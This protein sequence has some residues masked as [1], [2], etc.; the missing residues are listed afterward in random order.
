MAKKRLLRKAIQV[1][2][3]SVDYVDLNRWS[4]ENG[5]SIGAVIRDMVRRERERREWAGRDNMAQSENAGART[6]GRAA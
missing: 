1:R 4:V 5:C 2:L 6:T 3:T